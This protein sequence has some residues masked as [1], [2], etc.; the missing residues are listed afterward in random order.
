MK[1]EEIWL[2]VKLKK[3]K[4]ETENK[5]EIPADL[6]ISFCEDLNKKHTATAAFAA[7]LKVT[8]VDTTVGKI[9]RSIDRQAVKLMSKNPCCRVYD[10]RMSKAFNSS[11]QHP[12]K[13][14]CSNFVKMYIKF[15]PDLDKLDYEYLKLDKSET[16]QKEIMIFNPENLF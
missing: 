8:R 13:K 5:I 7:M 2:M 1:S 3:L 10:S 4:D 6:V 16:V 12:L 11:F 14:K 15:K 9:T